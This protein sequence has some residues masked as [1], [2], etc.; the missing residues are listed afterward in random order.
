LPASLAP[1]HA[2]QDLR[3]SSERVSKSQPGRKPF[4]AAA[5]AALMAFAGL[6]LTLW[7]VTAPETAVKGKAT[8]STADLWSGAGSIDLTVNGFKQLKAPPAIVLLGSSL[9]MH[10][11]YAMDA[12]T[13]R[14]IGDI[15]HHHQS[16]TL[17]RILSEQGLGQQHVYNLAVFGAMISDGFIYVN[18]YLQGEHCPKI[19]IFGVAPRDFSDSNLAAPTATF[20]FKKLVGLE[21][22]ARYANLYMPGWL[23]RADFVAEH[24]CYFYGKRW[25]LQ[26]EVEKGIT[27]VAKT[28][29]ITG[30]EPQASFPGAVSA[31]AG[32]M[33]G[34]TAEERF[35]LST[36]EY[37]K[38]YRG[39]DNKDLSLQIGFL[40]KTLA[41]CKDRGIKVLLV[42]MPLSDVNRALL[43]EGFYSHFCKTVGLEA[44]K[45]PNV[46]FFDLGESAEFL[47]SDYWDTAHLNQFGGRK[48]LNHLLPEI[49][50]SLKG[51]M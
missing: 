21:N 14:N 1:P 35:A 29:G 9:I 27:R 40:E 2:S 32:F 6:N 26:H 19:L 30:S 20:T 16:L 34:R 42:N 24:L 45:Y 25:R 18:D 11:F 23:D 33:S 8:D 37:R 48:L 5:V 43:P 41:T 31:N 51:S 17:E 22:F 3:A 7:K 28:F 10:P 12:E 38:R 47:H 39:I 4:F 15:F 46:K 50:Q 49:C 44:A 36:N 13:N